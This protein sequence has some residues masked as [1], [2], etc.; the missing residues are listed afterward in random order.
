MRPRLALIALTLAA[1]GCSGP[2]GNTYFVPG[3]DAD[4][5][6]AVLFPDAAVRDTQEIDTALSNDALTACYTPATPGGSKLDG[7]S[8]VQTAYYQCRSNKCFNLA[9]PAEPDDFRCTSYCEFDAECPSG[10]VCKPTLT[11]LVSDWLKSPWFYHQ[12]PAPGAYTLV[13]VC[14]WE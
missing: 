13:R 2:G 6:D 9:G 14:K 1:A 11:N 12:D 4:I 8:C 5:S 10:M 3:G 7:A